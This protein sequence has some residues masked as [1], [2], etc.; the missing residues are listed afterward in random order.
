MFECTG[1]D[2]K[3]T[4]RVYLHTIEMEHLDQLS[5]CGPAQIELQNVVLIKAVKCTVRFCMSENNIALVHL[6]TSAGDIDSAR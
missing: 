6:I 4:R 1:E 5:Y 2:T 3:V